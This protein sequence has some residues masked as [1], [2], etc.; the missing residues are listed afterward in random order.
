MAGELS[1]SGFAPAL[2]NAVANAV[3][4]RLSAFPIT[5]ERIYDALQNA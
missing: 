2:V 4:V 5:A 1:N 3:G